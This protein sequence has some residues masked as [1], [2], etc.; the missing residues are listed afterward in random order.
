MRN[1]LR[2]ATFYASFS[3]GCSTE[4]PGADPRLRSLLSIR[5]LWAPPCN[6]MKP[7][8]SCGQ[9]RGQGMFPIGKRPLLQCHGTVLFKDRR[10]FLSDLYSAVQFPL[11]WVFALLSSSFPLGSDPPGFRSVRDSLFHPLSLVMGN[12][13]ENGHEQTSRSIPSSKD[14]IMFVTLLHQSI[15]GLVPRV[16]VRRILGKSIR[17]SEFLDAG[18]PTSRPR[19]SREK[20]ALGSLRAAYRFTRRISQYFTRNESRPRP[21]RILS[22]LVRIVETV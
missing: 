16:V 9:S 5:S 11:R 12:V 8:G 4:F 17:V 13:Q 1:F 18:S 21:S 2:N 19:R 20:E 6:P 3:F 15:E 14:T 7:R 22:P 10:M